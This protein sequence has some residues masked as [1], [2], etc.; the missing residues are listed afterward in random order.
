MVKATVVSTVV[1]LLAITGCSEKTNPKIDSEI[2]A[3]IKK[4]ATQLPLQVSEVMSITGMERDC[5]FSGSRQS[6]ASEILDKL[7]LNRKRNL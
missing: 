1:L 4:M 5:I 3:D 7:F 2:D 6:T